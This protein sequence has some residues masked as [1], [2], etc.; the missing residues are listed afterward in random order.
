MTFPWPSGFVTCKACGR[1]TPTFGP[2]L[3]VEKCEICSIRF[4]PL[5]YAHHASQD[6]GSLERLKKALGG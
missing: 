3:E 4:V 6:D 1:A 2:D 5:P